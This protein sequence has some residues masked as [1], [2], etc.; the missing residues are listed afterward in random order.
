MISATVRPLVYLPLGN[1]FPKSIPYHGKLAL[2]KL[3]GRR[4]LLPTSE[5]ESPKINCTTLQSYPWIETPNMVTI[6][7]NNTAINFIFTDTQL[8]FLNM[9]LKT[10]E[11]DRWNIRSCK[12]Y[13]KLGVLEYFYG[14]KEERSR[15]RELDEPTVDDS[16]YSKVQTYCN[17]PFVL[18]VQSTDMAY[19]DLFWEITIC[20][21]HYKQSKY[22]DALRGVHLT[23]FTCIEIVGLFGSPFGYY[24]RLHTQVIKFAASRERKRKKSDCWTFSKILVK[25]WIKFRND[26]KSN[27]EEST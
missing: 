21:R 20:L 12:V 17:Y 9:V 10:N 8:C 15:Q 27:I 25:S 14:K 3:L 6:I 4:W 16:K 5:S 7:A 11:K 22:G 18:H 1:P 24:I 23:T 19:G 26:S 13:G 2:A